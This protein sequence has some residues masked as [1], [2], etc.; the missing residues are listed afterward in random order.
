MNICIRIKQS[1]TTSDSSVSKIQIS[2]SIEICVSSK[3][4]DLAL[5]F[6]KTLH[7]FILLSCDQLASLI[8]NLF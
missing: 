8:S 5:F 4:V 3:T 1:T 2:K 7:I 6:K